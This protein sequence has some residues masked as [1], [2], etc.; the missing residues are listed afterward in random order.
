MTLYR[1]ARKGCS[2]EVTFRQSPE[3]GKR[4]GWP[5]KSGESPHQR[6]SQVKAPGVLAVGPL[7]GHVSG[8][9]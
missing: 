1:V 4:G 8:A 7:P 6:D 9:E 5:Q 2:E 3:R